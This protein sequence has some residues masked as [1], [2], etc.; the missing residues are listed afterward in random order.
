MKNVDRFVGIAFILIAVF[1][2]FDTYNLPDDS[3]SYP[4]V[5]IGVMALL[6]LMIFIK[7]FISKDSKSWK[8]LFGHINWKRFALVG[9]AS[10]LYLFGI[11]ILGYFSATILYLFVLL[12]FLKANK[13]TMIITIPIFTLGIYFVFKMFLKVPLPTGILI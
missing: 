8:E 4:R 7:S 12:F 6:A 3:Q 2:F 1:F 11:N 9:V 13:R 10:L 5:L